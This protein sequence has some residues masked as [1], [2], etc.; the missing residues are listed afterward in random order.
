MIRRAFTMLLKPGGLADYKRN[1]DAMWPELIAEFKRQGIARITIFERDPMLFLY[2]E[3]EDE[4]AWTR[5]WQS[6]VHERW[7]EIHVPLLQMRDDGIVES[8]DLS[9]IFHLDSSAG[10]LVGR[11]KA[12]DKGCGAV[13][14]LAR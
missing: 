11:P 5:L 4:E 14:D 8:A 7:A 3:I 12:S 10:P 9:E 13:E 6:K 2:S 1:H